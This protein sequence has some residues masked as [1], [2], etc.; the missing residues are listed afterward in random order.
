[1]ESVD[2]QLIKEHYNQHVNEG[3]ST[4]EVSCTR[5][6]TAIWLLKAQEPHHIDLHCGH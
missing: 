3:I 6:F 4:K 1:M 2:K 5:H